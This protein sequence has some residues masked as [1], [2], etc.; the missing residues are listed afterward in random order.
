[1][2]SA[3]ARLSAVV[4]SIGPDRPDEAATVFC[5]PVAEWL[6]IHHIAWDAL[7]K[8]RDKFI[9]RSWETAV[10]ISVSGQRALQR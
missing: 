9:E 8:V 5:A 2:L 4:D 10:V 3:F 7:D 6:A 1:L